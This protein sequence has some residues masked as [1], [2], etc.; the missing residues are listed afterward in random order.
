MLDSIRWLVPLVFAAAALSVAP[1]A[2]AQDSP[3]GSAADSRAPGDSAAAAGDAPAA[4]PA[5]RDAKANSFDRTPTSCVTLSNIKQ[6]VVVDDSTILFYM[7]GGS[8]PTY[9]TSLPHECPNLAREG[10]F[11]YTTPMN[12]LC[13]SDL[14]TVLE[15]FGVGLR[16]GFTCR[17]GLFYPIPYEE[18]ELLRKEHDKPGS[19]RGGVK[20][21]PA[22][23]PPKKQAAPAAPSE[24]ATAGAPEPTSEQAPQGDSAP[25]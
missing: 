21:K 23:L 11:R 9:R 7:R 15:Q 20:T 18:A 22:E 1:D 5:A 16:D 3:G 2:A 25:R 19:A 4:N 17:L 24:P 10:R 12:R 8:K 6:T 13:D 14:I